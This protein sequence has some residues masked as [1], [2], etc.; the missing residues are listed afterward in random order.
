MKKLLKFIALSVYLSTLMPLHAR[1]FTYTYEGQ[2]ITYTVLDE[3]AKTCATKAGGYDEIEDK[4]VEIF[5]KHIDEII[6]GKPIQ[7]ITNSQE[8][9]GLD[10]LESNFNYL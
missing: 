3:E 8:F 6:T 1:D 2:T 4:Y 9:Y 10:F 5:E 7:Y